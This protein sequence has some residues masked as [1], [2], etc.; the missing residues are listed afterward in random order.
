MQVHEYEVL[1]QPLTTHTHFSAEEL[2]GVCVNVAACVCVYNDC[3]HCVY[4]C[5]C[6]CTR[7]H[8]HAR[9]CACVRLYVY[10]FASVCDL[11]GEL[12]RMCV[13]IKT[14]VVYHV[15]SRYMSHNLS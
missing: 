3:I 10:V 14:Q 2:R 7:A 1:F 9:A 8:E 12:S 13:Q 5:V 6:V 15:L 11:W 4:V